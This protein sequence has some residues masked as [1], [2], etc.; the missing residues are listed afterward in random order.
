MSET[1]RTHLRVRASELVGRNWL[2]TGGKSLD[3]ESLRGK[4]VL[5]DFWTFC[6]INCLHVL[7]ELRP[8]EQQYSDVLVTV[9]VH[10]PKFEHEADPGG[11]G[12]RR[13]AL[14]DPPPGPG[15]PRAGHLEG[16]HRPRLAHP[17]GHRPR[18][19][20]RG[21]P[22]RRRPRRRPRRADPR[23]DRR[24]RGQGHPAPRRR[25]LRGAGADVGHPAVPGQ[26]PVPARR[27]RRRNRARTPVPGWSPTPA[28]TA[29]WSSP[30]TSRPCSA[31]TAPAKRATPTA[32]PRPPASTSRRAWCCCRRT[33]PRRPATTSSSPTP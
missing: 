25:P 9:G 8:L 10:S 30:P 1:V 22:L 12:R 2:N 27:P 20:H 26:G 18:G 29:S 33:S 23:A 19:L 13:G 24:A 5:L 7:D 14:R 32:T 16:L 28:T 31:P 6:C 21:A 4:I 15:R 11:A 3:L 17:G